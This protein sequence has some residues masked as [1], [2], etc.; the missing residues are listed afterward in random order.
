MR[1]CSPPQPA[2]DAGIVP[3]AAVLVVIAAMCVGGRILVNVSQSKARFPPG[4]SAVTRQNGPVAVSTLSWKL[5]YGSP[6]T[7]TMVAALV[8]LMARMIRFARI[9]YLCAVNVICGCIVG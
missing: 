9:I 8:T 1:V 6:E 2:A 7:G 3:T 5:E 4:P